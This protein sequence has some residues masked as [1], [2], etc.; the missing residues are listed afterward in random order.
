MK[1]RVLREVVSDDPIERAYLI[2]DDDDEIIETLEIDETDL[3]VRVCGIATLR[4][5]RTAEYLDRVRKLMDDAAEHWAYG[6][7]R[8][9]AESLEFSR[10]Q[11]RV[12]IEFE[13]VSLVRESTQ[14]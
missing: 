3:L 2:L 13:A 6:E 10:G 12:H 8:R 14:S 9:R 4:E 7:A 11:V 1:V 5:P